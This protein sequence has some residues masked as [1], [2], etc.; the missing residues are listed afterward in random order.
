MS[1]AAIETQL[2]AEN[3]TTTDDLGER[4][5]PGSVVYETALAGWVEAMES[6]AIAA[7]RTLARDALAA[8]WATL[9]AWIRGPYSHRFSETVRLLDAGD[10]DA[11]TA[12]IEY[13]GPLAAFS[14]EQAEAFE[15]IRTELLAAVSALPKD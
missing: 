1:R 14:V 13:A 15:M 4:H 11:A 10:D 7:A 2:R 6:A 8:Q 3:P 9:P 5:G 12:L